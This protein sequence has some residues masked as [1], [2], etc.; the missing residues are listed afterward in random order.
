MNP[1]VSFSV[2]CANLTEICL[3]GKGHSEYKSIALSHQD[4][5]LSSDLNPGCYFGSS[6][7]A[8]KPSHA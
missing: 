5:L 3:I 4:S 2:F 1:Y 8:H 7:D 6:L